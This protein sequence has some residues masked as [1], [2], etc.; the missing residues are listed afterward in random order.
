MDYSIRVG[1][2]YHNDIVSFLEEAYDGGLF[3]QFFDYSFNYKR[4]GC[5]GR[6][7]PSDDDD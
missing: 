7:L 2:R 1:H 3:A 4:T 5:L 6:V